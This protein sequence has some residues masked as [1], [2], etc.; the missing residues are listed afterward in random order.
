[1]ATCDVD[2]DVPLH[3]AS[4]HLDVIYHTREAVFHWDSQ[5]SRRELKIRRAAEMYFNEI[6][7]TWIVEH[8]LECLIYLLKQ[9]KTKE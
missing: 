1:M 5:T 4:L 3:T 6:R 2:R 8:C 7:G 9:K